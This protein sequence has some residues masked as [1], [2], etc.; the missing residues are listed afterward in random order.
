MVRKRAGS[1]RIIDTFA[2]RDLHEYAERPSVYSFI[3]HGVSTGD[4]LRMLRRSK[5]KNQQRN[6]GAR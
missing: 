6:M 5:K 2:A 3:K 4:G 1:L